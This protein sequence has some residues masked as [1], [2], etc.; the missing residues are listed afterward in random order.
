MRSLGISG[1]LQDLD[2][3]HEYRAEGV[4]LK[5]DGNSWGH[6]WIEFTRSEV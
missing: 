3:G 2:D 1:L 6:D 4:A 5:R